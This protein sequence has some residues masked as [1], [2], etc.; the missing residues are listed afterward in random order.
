MVGERMQLLGGRGD[1]SRGGKPRVA[2][3]RGAGPS[4]DGVDQSPEYDHE[5]SGHAGGGPDDDIPF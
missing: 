5:S 3:G 2:A 4:E 1:G